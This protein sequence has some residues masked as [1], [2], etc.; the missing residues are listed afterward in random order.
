MKRPDRGGSVASL[1][2]QGSMG[3]PRVTRT[4]I[5]GLGYTQ[6]NERINRNSSMKMFQMAP[7]VDGRNQKYTDEEANT[8]LGSIFVALSNKPNDK[9]KEGYITS[10]NLRAAFEQ[11]GLDANDASLQLLIDDVDENGDGK[12]SYNEFDFVMRKKLFG[13]MDDQMLHAFATL[14]NDN[15]GYISTVEFKRIL[16]TEGRYPLSDREADE[17]M[18]FAD[19]NDDGL[20]DYQNFL[21]WLNEPDKIRET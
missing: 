7:M 18:M 8:L 13:Q 3:G 6:V 10:E 1:H 9:N 19:S 11:H 5:A 16:M 4:E 14:D 15:D 17:L 12:L 21:C 20:V 2:S